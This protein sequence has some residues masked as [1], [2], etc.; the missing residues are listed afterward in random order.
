MEASSLATEQIHDC[1]GMSGPVDELLLRQVV[2]TVLIE[3][4]EELL[5]SLLCLLVALLASHLEYR[6]DYFPGLLAADLAV[7]IHVVHTVCPVQLLINTSTRCDAQSRHK[8]LEINLSIAICVICSKN[9]F[10]KRAGISSLAKGFA[11]HLHKSILVDYAGWE[12][13]PE[14]T[15]PVPDLLRGEFGDLFQLLHLLL[16][17]VCTLNAAYDSISHVFCQCQST[18]M[19][20]SALVG[21]GADLTSYN[22][23]VKSPLYLCCVMKA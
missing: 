23:T 18:I 15:V 22:A 8:L 11:V 17:V 12:V 6:N 19:C 3:L 10:C 9:M 2:I 13:L 7:P 16:A 1:G 4:A 14:N 21:H 5:H 20:Q